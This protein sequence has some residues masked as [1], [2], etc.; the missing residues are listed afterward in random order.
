M[1]RARLRVRRESDLPACVEAL[2]AVHEVDRYPMVWPEDPT[3]WLSPPGTAASWVTELSGAIVG[4]VLLTD[5]GASLTALHRLFVVPAARSAGLATALLSA[6]IEHAHER[7]L[8]L[9]LDVVEDSVAAIALYERLG[10][11]LTAR[12]PAPFTWPDG[13]RPI[14]RRYVA[15]EAR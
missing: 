5:E 2:R 11:T 1:D 12:V 7:G 10:W 13:T 8:A 15:P 9:E 3:G 6:A 4:H 14:E